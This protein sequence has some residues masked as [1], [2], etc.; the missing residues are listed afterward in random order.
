VFFDLELL[1]PLIQLRQLLLS[2][3]NKKRMYL[4]ARLPGGLS[5][6]SLNAENHA[7]N[8]WF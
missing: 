8:A 3:L 6:C 4:A 5:F 1:L 2:L 7:F